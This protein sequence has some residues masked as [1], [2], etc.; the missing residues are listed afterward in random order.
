MKI[1]DRKVTVIALFVSTLFLA[2]CSARAE[3]ETIAQAADSVQQ[4]ESPASDEILLAETYTF[5]GFGFSIDY[6]AGWSAETRDTVTVIAELKS[7]LSTA[8]Q[9]D[10]PPDEGAGISL[11]QRTLVYMRGIGL[12]EEPTLE[13]LFDLNKAFFQWQ[14]SVEPQEAEAF[15]SPALAVSTSNDEAW[16]HTLMGYAN[17]RAF[18]LQI[19]APSEE[20]LDDLM[21]TWEQI[22]A[23]IQPVEE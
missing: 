19:S 23:S 14:E 20:K 6:P 10:G 7:D 11:D 9:D 16:S 17:D 18:L 12:G 21:P 2:A 15:H 13:N 5:P 4:S 3:E 22:L 1:F 8:F